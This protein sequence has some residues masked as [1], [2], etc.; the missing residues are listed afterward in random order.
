MNKLLLLL[1]ILI[2][3]TACKTEK[4]GGSTTAEPEV[5]EK[6]DLSK[7]PEAGPYTSQTNIIYDQGFFFDEKIQ[8]DEI[9]VEKIGE[10]LYDVVMYFNESTDFEMLETYKVSLILY[11]KNPDELT[12]KKERIKKKKKIPAKAEVKILDKTHVVVINNIKVIPKEFRKINIHL[13]NNESALNNKFLIFEDI[14][15]E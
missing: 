4:K 9:S 1:M 15:F 11:P 7:Y 5:I 2:T 8:L 6:A 13:Y 10:N 12:I 3:A 14:I